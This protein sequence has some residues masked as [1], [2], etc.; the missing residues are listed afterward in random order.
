M[1]SPHPP[2]P[3]SIDSRRG[4][5]ATRPQWKGAAGL[6]ADVRYY[7]EWMRE[8]AFE[9]IGH[10]YPKAQGRNG[11][12]LALGADGHQ[13]KSRSECAGAAGAVVCAE[14]EEGARACWA[15]PD[16]S[17]ESRVQISRFVLNGCLP[18]K[19]QEG[20]MGRQIRQGGDCMYQ[21]RAY[22]LRIPPSR[23]QSRNAW[24]HRR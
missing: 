17:M 14:Q 18:P 19:G 9:R 10:L 20:T 24:A 21:W 8:R 11:D 3:A 16:S 6:A 4:E 15:T 5:A 7:G 22:L 13:S 1:C 12:R 2:T 23:R